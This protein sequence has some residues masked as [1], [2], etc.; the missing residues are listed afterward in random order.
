[1]I[2]R[3]GA[4]VIGK[5]ELASA[6][7]ARVDGDWARLVG[8]VGPCTHAPKP[9]REPFEALVRAV[10]HQQLHARAAEA[11]VARLV[12]L[13]PGG[14]PFPTPRALRDLDASA[15]RGCGFSA[16]KVATLY[17]LAE[18]ALSGL[19]PAREAALQMSD[20]ELTARLTSLPGIGA[21]TV[22]MMLIYTL[23]REDVFPVDDFGVRE[24]F[25][26]LKALERQPT[27]SA[28][29]RAGEALRPY[30]T[31]ASWYLWRVPK[32][33]SRAAGS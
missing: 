23:E 24:G 5:Y 15:L 10:A 9:A 16:R 28:L 1:M 8:D 7:L 32:G 12:A 26:R 3:P 2:L 27:R 29:L 25:R 4:P 17:A 14:E 20:G 33:T 18:G 30:R 31:I 13:S 19:V 11:M 21:W 22:E 6:T